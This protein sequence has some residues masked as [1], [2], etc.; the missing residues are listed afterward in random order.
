MFF[1]F[2]LVTAAVQ[3][4]VITM[5]QIGI[6]IFSTKT[7]IFY[8]KVIKKNVQK[9]YRPEGVNTDRL[10]GANKQST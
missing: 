1:D 2:G 9:P 5:K 8:L 10:N 4:D 3:Y 6:I 7:N